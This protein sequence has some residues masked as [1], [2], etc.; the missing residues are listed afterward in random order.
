M[1]RGM[2]VYDIHTHYTVSKIHSVVAESIAEAERIFSGKYRDITIN[3]ISLH[4]EYV[5]IQNY[6]E[7]ANDVEE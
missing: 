5:Q 7:Q 3:S 1:G 6:D 4:S 2:K